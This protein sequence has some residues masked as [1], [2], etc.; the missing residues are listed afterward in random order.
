MYTV[1]NENLQV[2][3]RLSQNN[4]QG[5]TA[6]F[7]DT[8][9]QQ[10]ATDNS[11]D[12]ASLTSL[13]FNQLDKKGNAKQWNHTL[14]ISIEATGLGQSINTK[15]YLMYFDAIANHHYLMKVLDVASDRNSGYVTVSAINSA[16]Y[17]LG[18]QL[19]NNE[20]TYP[21]SNLKD[22]VNKAYNNVPFSLRIQ[23]DLLTVI[24]YTISANTS[25]QAVL[26]DLQTKYDVDVD[27]WVEVDN[28]GNITERVL[29]FGHL[30]QDNGELIRYGGAKGFEN[31]TA[32]EVSDII[33]TKIYVTG[34]TDDKDIVKGHI[35]SVNNGLEYIV[36]D[37]ANQRIYAV[38]ASQQQP[39]YLEGTIT[40]ELLSEPQA[41]LD[42]AKQQMD[43]FNHPRFNYTVTPMH[44]Q[45]VT[46]GDA[47]T[48]QDFH[49]KPEILVTSK[50]IQKSTS[51]ASPETN[52]FVLGEFSSIF[53]EN[54]NKGAGIITLIKKD[55]TVVQ[56]AA[57]YAKAQ[58]DEA[59]R[60]A[61]TAQEQAIHAQTSAD[62]KTMSFT[63]ASVEDLP[64][65]ANEGD[66]AWVTLE[67]GTHGYTFI[68]GHWIEDINPSLKKSIQDGVTTAI[69]TAKAD[70][71]KSIADNNTSINNT[72]NEVAQE[73]I[74]L[75]IKDGD[76]NNKAQAMADKALSDAKANATQVAQDALNSANQNLAD[77]KKSLTDGI[78]KEASDRASAVNALDTKAQGYAD[79][80]KKN[81]ID[82]ATSAD[83]I[84]NKK[85]DDTASSITSTVSQNKKDAEGKITTAQ[86][87]ATQ[88]LNGLSS[89]VDTAIYNAKTGQLST[90]VTNVT[91]TANQAKTD[92]ASIKQT[93]TTQ[94]AR[95]T[96]I[97]ADASGVKT[98][99]SDLQTAQGK[100]S[101]YISTLQQR[102]DGFDA[103]VTKVNNL[104]VGGRN[105]LL[106]TEQF[107]GDLNPRWEWVNTWDADPYN[108]HKT[109]QTGSAWGGP[110]YVINDLFNRK[111]VEPNTDYTL[112]VKIKNTSNDPIDIYFYAPAIGILDRHII[113]L[114]PNSGWTTIST[115]FQFSDIDPNIGHGTM[116]FEP[117][118][119]IPS[120]QGT[121]I[122]TE[123]KFERGNI[124][125]DW[126]PA[127]EDVDSATA[128]A[129]LTADN[130]TLAV[131]KLTN[132]DG[133][134]T[135]A[136]SD[137][138]ANADAI[139]QTVSKTVYDQNNGDLNQAISKAQSTA[140]GVVS[141][142]GN[143]KT[144]NDGRVKAAESKI[145]QNA[146]DITARVTQ[147]D[148]N[149]NKSQLNTRFTK[150]EATANG[151]STTVG[152]LQTAVNNL[153][154]IN[155]LFNTEFSPDFQG[156]TAGG[157]PTNAN[158]ITTE[159]TLMGTD[160]FG[161]NVVSHK[162]GGDWINSAPI[163]VT[164]GMALSFSSRLSVPKTVTSGTPVALYIMAFNATNSRVLSQGYNIPLNQLTSTPTTFKYENIVMPSGAVKAFAVYTWN[165]ADE[166]YIS[167]PMLVFSD[168]VG[169]YVQGNYNNNAALAQVKITADSVSSIVS[170]PTTGLSTRVQTAEGTLNT[171]KSTADGAMS[172]ASQTANAIT[173][174]ISDRKTGDNNT[175]Q[176]SK[177]FTQSQI[178]SATTGINSTITQT[179]NAILVNI[180]ATNLFMNSEFNQDYGWR[181]KTGTISYLPNQNVDNQFHGIVRL[182]T[183]TD[184]YQGYWAKNIPVQ[185]GSK[186]SGSVKVH[187]NNNGVAAGFS[188]YD[189]WFVDKNG[190]RI[191]TGSGGSV[192]LTTKMV[193]SPYWVD[194]WMDGVTAPINAVYAQV[195]L[196][197]T[198]ATGMM[199][200]FT[201]PTFTA[202]DV[203]QPYSPNDDISAQLS[204]FK[205]NWSIGITDNISKIT[206]GIVG[207]ASQMSLISKK[208]II[209]S[210]ST[211][212]TGTAWIKSAMIANG[213]IGTAQI[214][215]A[216]ITSA[217]IANLD[218]SKL[219]GDTIT[220]F[221]F[222]VNRSMNIASGG[223]IKS[224][225]INMDKTSFILNTSTVATDTVT[226]AANN[227]MMLSNV[228]YSIDSTKGAII[229]SGKVNLSRT[230]GS[231]SNANFD[232]RIAPDYFSMSSKNWSDGSNDNYMTMADYSVS[233]LAGSPLIDKAS[234]YSYVGQ[235]GIETT[236]TVLAD[237]ISGH[238]SKPMYINAGGTLRL[239]ANDGSG[240]KVYISNTN[241]QTDSPIISGNI[242]LNTG[243]A[244]ISNDN[245][246]MFFYGSNGN[247]IDLG[248][249]SLT[250]SSLVSLKENISKVIPKQ[251]LSETL[252]AELRSY[253][254]TGDDITDK[255]VTPMI[256]DVNHEMYIPNDWLSP[257][258]TGVDTYS[259]IGYLIGSV[260]AL[261]E[262]IIELK[263]NQ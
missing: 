156:W 245:G 227:K 29:Y 16:I 76:F 176:S 121:I 37:D 145:E 147:T 256:D 90:D 93:D 161:S 123:M 113:K 181:Q 170:D 155:Q 77:A 173:Q 174:E 108:G 6:F 247:Q 184:S 24:D 14:N 92:I 258:G 96:T 168:H 151:A 20:T 157:N 18:K 248:V 250:Q 196:L 252:R 98:T 208:V 141:T 199:A 110:K 239:A 203:H 134:I 118:S 69:S 195:S 206:S 146:K 89:K 263:A 125:T 163:T 88:A 202:T 91:Q 214:G 137:I 64:V 224:D 17:E 143:Y 257:E 1:L 140:D 32:T 231:T 188:L 122:Q 160:G 107:T 55:V 97:E 211:Q 75:A 228:T 222:N 179:A 78:S 131:G 210:P 169:T 154:Q 194:L 82:V 44:D 178:T 52:T 111:V 102:A 47:I 26:Q 225:V 240:V 39:V 49:I 159:F 62:G 205:D 79:T 204:L 260:K 142:V 150:V 238:G 243:H 232:F 212:I 33:Y 171:V 42:W 148:Y 217:K 50:V 133:V 139:T 198:G 207:N 200:D 83:G 219:T 193:S 255:H 63:V 128:K 177:D 81:A 34:K 15:D 2:K 136:Q 3:G 36:D 66:I 249:K 180:S 9:V 235:D 41:L 230:N 68:N 30:G 233:F 129:Q 186:Y 241:V 40:N 61:V 11:N 189:L 244:I 132:A 80:A 166:V 117:S 57:D 94:D 109:V 135:K 192:H 74:D 70:T 236:G 58:A 218:V 185:G 103:T 261:Q 104:S 251:L 54:A 165:V 182:V 201:M 13:D 31:M 183:T 101:G 262:Q 127:P 209:D 119:G 27:S 48:V 152:K 167:Q 95:M 229:S 60:Q 138:K 221:N 71:E 254:F 187:F 35:G 19:V 259:V 191:S 149:N 190:T 85:I 10:L 120:G 73:K 86:S 223:V 234:S 172:K 197:A 72:V 246:K 67:D 112:S 126:T 164:A 84:I 53:T 22:V 38:G 237:A 28:T 65:K 226:T 253:N 100:Q 242:T 114:P 124:T 8:V 99:V 7:A 216:V 23:D 59:H 56:A 87:T 5:S 220:G 21:K 4:G 158:P 25:L 162:G 12:P 115:T 45:I 51:F 213:A 43:I 153:G 46:I 175:L 215:D 105:L 116:R 106:G 130:A 144:S